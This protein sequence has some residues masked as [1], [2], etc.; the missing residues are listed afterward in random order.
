GLESVVFLD[1][2]P[3][4]QIPALA[5]EADAFVLTALHRPELYRYGVS[6]NKLFDYMAAARP[7]VIAIDSVNNP[8]A[9][10]DAGIT[11]RP[12]DRES[13][14]Q[15]ILELA[16]MSPGERAR[17]G[18]NGRRFLAERHDYPVLATRFAQV[19]DEVAAGS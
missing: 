13:L 15:A 17:R 8:V 4:G 7:I 16:R 5:A 12:E 18:D 10:A 1:P 14:A 11:V 9:E 2:V 3:N 19:L 6:M